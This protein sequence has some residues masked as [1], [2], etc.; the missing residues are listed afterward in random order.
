MT[1]TIHVEEGTPFTPETMARILHAMLQELPKDVTTVRYTVDEGK[2]M[3]I[4]RK[5]S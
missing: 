1:I 5:P 4:T 2:P 3:L